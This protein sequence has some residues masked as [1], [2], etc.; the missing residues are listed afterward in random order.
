MWI[1]LIF[2]VTPPPPPHASSSHWV[3]VWVWALS[4]CPPVLL[5]LLVHVAGHNTPSQ[6]SPCVPLA[7][8]VL[9][10]SYGQL[11][12][13]QHLTR[14]KSGCVKASNCHLSGS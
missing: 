9:L 3:I 7:R 14:K 12:L 6:F 10:V 8:L 5:C 11:L 4:Y 2:V 13:A 1:S